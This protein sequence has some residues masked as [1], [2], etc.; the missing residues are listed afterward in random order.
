MALCLLAGC[1]AGPS[2]GALSEEAV[3]YVQVGP[4]EVLPYGRLARQCGTPA[5]ALGKQ[6]ARYPA[7]GGGYTLYDSEP[8]GSRARS[9]FLTGFDDGCARQFT[10]AFVIFSAPSD[11]ERLRYGRPSETVPRSG[12]DTAYEVL[13][14]QICGVGADAPCGARIG[15]LERNTAFVSIYE[16]F[17]SNPRW[18]T[19]LV[20]DGAVLAADL[21]GD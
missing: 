19:M 16:T 4:G 9:F 3:D 5:R 21:S 17:G 14:A 18:K 11:F 1:G 12:T 15:R 7:G 10:A 13:K 20:H 2:G 6:V 8:G